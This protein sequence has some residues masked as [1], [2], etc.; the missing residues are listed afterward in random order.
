MRRG[1]LCSLALVLAANVAS[2]AAQDLR[3]ALDAAA[4]FTPVYE[5]TKLPGNIRQIVAIA[6]LSDPK[7]QRLLATFIA[8]DSGEKLGEIS[9][10]VRNDAHVVFRYAAQKDWLAGKYRVDVA[11]D[12]KAWR[13]AAWEV[14]APAPDVPAASAKTVMPLQ[15]GTSWPMAFVAW[16]SPGIKVSAP[17]NITPEPGGKYRLDARVTVTAA[18]SDSAHLRYTRDG[19][20][21]QE[22]VWQIGDAGIGIRQQRRG[23]KVTDFNPP[24]PVVPFPLHGPHAEWEWR[25]NA[26]VRKFQLWGPLPL[27]GLEHDRLGYVILMRQTGPRQTQTLERDFIPGVGIARE[28]MVIQ[29]GWGATLVHQESTLTALPSRLGA[30]DQKDSPSTQAAPSR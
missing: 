16:A 24:L 27:G 12:G 29:L 21:A 9:Y 18:D 13:S 20:L 4:D 30:T 8:V 2:A 22:E 10:P 23:D 26:D 5:F 6:D 7:P 1:L 28:V 25:S 17:P 3:M 11:A 15:P 14:V 19:R